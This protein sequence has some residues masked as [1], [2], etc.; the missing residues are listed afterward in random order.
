MVYQPSSNETG[1]LICSEKFERILTETYIKWSRVIITAGDFNID[2]LNGNKQSQCCNK[3][4]LNSFSL[5]QHM[6]K[7]TRKSKT[8][9]DHVPSLIPHGVVLIMIFCILWK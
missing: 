3:D 7:G 5:H 1:K 4:M 6:A 9:I 8:L 2:L